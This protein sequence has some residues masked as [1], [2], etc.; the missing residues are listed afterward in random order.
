MKKLLTCLLSV[1]VCVIAGASCAGGNASGIK[2]V[3]KNKTEYKIGVLQVDTHTALDAAKN[4]FTDTLDA[5][6][7]ENGKKITYDLQNAN[8]DGNNETTMAANLVAA[9]NDILLGV[10]TSSARKLATSTTK[11]PT[12]FTAVTD[13]ERSGL[14]GKNVTGTSDIAPIDRQIDLIKALVPDCEKIA[15]VY[16]S[17]EENSETQITLAEEA[18]KN[19]GLGYRRFPVTASNDIQTVV[20]SITSDYGAAY[21][22]TDNLL[23]ANM[24]TACNVLKTKGIPVVAGEAG[25]CE[26]NE[27]VATLG[28]DYY[29]LGVQTAQMA[30]KIL[31]G[32]SP[33][34]LPCERYNKTVTLY[35]NESNAKACGLTDE[36]IAAVKSA[37]AA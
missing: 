9:K 30:I 22:P 2:L 8:G 36:R 24:I 34:N 21:I 14:T 27:G 23:A 37:F 7:K 33:E 25:M 17:A 11:I 12:L 15:L 10:A 28:I 18:C 5:W 4:G 6:A 19:A 32:E 31:G 26:D 29:Q 35:L 13:P 3:D 20:E 1:C 16:C